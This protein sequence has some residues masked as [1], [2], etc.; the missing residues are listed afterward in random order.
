MTVG[1]LRV[2]KGTDMASAFKGLPDDMCP[3]PHYGYLLSGRMRM[4]TKDGEHVYEAG[5]AYYWAPGHVP[6]PLED[7][8]LVEFSPT[9]E[10]KEVIAHIG[11]SAQG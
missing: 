2:P 6:E 11:R 3:C 10:F 5:R 4:R 9:E 1:F 7:C 8:E